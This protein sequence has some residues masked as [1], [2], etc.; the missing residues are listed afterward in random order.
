MMRGFVCPASRCSPRPCRF[1]SRSPNDCHE[2]PPVA[3]RSRARRRCRAW[4]A[5]GQAG[6][7]AGAQG[8]P[9][10]GVVGSAPV[11]G[12]H[13][14][15]ALGGGGF[16]HADR[17]QSGRR[18]GGNFRRDAGGEHGRVAPGGA[19]LAMDAPGRP[20]LAGS[21][22]HGHAGRR[23]PGGGGWRAA[24]PGLRRPVDVAARLSGRGRPAW[25][26]VAGRRPG[27]TMFRALC[28]ASHPVAQVGRG[29]CRGGA[30]R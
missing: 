25:V 7:R 30:R 19:C 9:I 23:G 13:G 26:G 5:R 11:A 4:P 14:H 20:W 29:L 2:Y 1:L 8:C 24:G 28:D 6:W 12:H 27:A 15:A 16:G 10:P 18:R 3:A 17:G 22:R 21:H